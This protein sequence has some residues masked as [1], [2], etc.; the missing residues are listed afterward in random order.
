VTLPRVGVVRTYESTHK[1]A[2]RVERGSARIRLATVSSRGGRWFCSFS[3][4]IT[5]HDPAP[6]RPEA[7]VGVD[8]GM[9]S[10]AVLST[11]EIVPNPKHLEIALRELRRLQRRTARGAGPDRTGAPVET[12]G[13]VAPDSGSHRD[14]A[15]A[16]G[17]R[18]P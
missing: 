6:G 9:K 11:G 5:R 3:V 15:Y 14:A 8:L 2:R 1:L 4:E 12:V 17:E 10:L 13:A 18:A 7:T 16:C